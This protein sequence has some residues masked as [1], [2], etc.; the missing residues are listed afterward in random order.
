[1]LGFSI[2]GLAA[3]ITMVWPTQ[4]S[5]S[6]PLDREGFR[7]REDDQNCREWSMGKNNLSIS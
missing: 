7:A 1:M 6:H 5:G 2:R 4:A 3:A